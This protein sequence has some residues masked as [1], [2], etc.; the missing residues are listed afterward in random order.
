VNVRSLA[1]LDALVVLVGSIA[2]ALAHLSEIRWGVFILF[3]AVIDLVGYIPGAIAFR[4][5]NRGSISTTYHALYNVTHGL[6]W[7]A[8]TAG[9]W[10]LLVRPEWA[11]LAIPIHLAGDRC[12]F[13]NFFKATNTPFES[14][15]APA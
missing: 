9:L 7:N 12:L 5:A 11:L 15:G 8:L 4:K 3:F 14:Q 2:L 1:R 6:P 10:C 13:G